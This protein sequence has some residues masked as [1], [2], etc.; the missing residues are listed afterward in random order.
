M[1]VCKV[2]A[3]PPAQVIWYKNGKVYPKNDK[4]M[5]SDGLT[6][7]IKHMQP[8]DQAKYKCEVKNSITSSE[9]P[10][11]IRM[12]GVGMIFIKSLA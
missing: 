9:C 11:A 8:D 12:S 10:F 4:S 1:F 5:S 3:Y 2:D 6:L 7:T